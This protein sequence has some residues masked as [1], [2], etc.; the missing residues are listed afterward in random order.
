MDNSHKQY[1]ARASNYK[2]LHPNFSEMPR[3]DQL[4]RHEAFGQGSGLNDLDTGRL[5][6]SYINSG[7]RAKGSYSKARQNLM[8]FGQDY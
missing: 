5:T 6:N 7:V 4:I 1:S 8:N 3:S 2:R